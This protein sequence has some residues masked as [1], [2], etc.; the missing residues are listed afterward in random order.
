MPLNIKEWER[1]NEPDTTHKSFHTSAKTCTLLMKVKFQ[2][3]VREYSYNKQQY[4][5]DKN[6]CI[7][8]VYHIIYMLNVNTWF[9]QLQIN[10]TISIKLYSKIKSKYNLIA[11]FVIINIFNLNKKYNF[12]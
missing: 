4:N 1:E 9:D 11:I 6:S 7:H 5:N 12:N 8:I 2:Y 10:S 3:A